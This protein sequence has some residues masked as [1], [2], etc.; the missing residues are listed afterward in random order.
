MRVL[1]RRLRLARAERELNALDALPRRRGRRAR[2]LRPRPPRRHPADPHPRLA[3]RVH[4]APAAG[5]APAESFDLVIPS[6][7]GYGFSERPDRCTTRDIASLWHT[8]MR[9][10]ATSATARAAATGAPAVT[11][12]MAL[13][14]RRAARHPPLQPR[15]RAAADGAADRGERAFLA[16]TAP[17]GRDE[18]GYSFI[19]GTA[20]DAGLR[21]HRLARG[22]AAG[23]SRSGARGPTPAATRGRFDRDFLLAL[24]T[25]Y[26][27]TGTISTS[28]RDYI[29]NRDAGTAA[30][31]TVRHRAAPGSPTSTTTSS[32]R[33]C[34][35]ASGPS[36][37][38]RRALHGHAPRRPL[39]R[40]RGNRTCSPPS[41]APSSSQ[42][43]TLRRCSSSRYCSVVRG[44]TSPLPQSRIT[45]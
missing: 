3:E 33:A 17:L 31:S 37:S 23:S 9:A 36:A 8:L 29:D 19:Q 38:T 13:D 44:S 12:Y 6:L 16:A 43:E 26:W 7:P 5:R 39:R 34:C 35:R 18:R 21:P 4:R 10:S 42:A 24:V 40:R 20:P 1:G 14:A 45:P 30:L 2:A 41:Y 27:V 22:L 15:Q 11:T 32:T 25:L 28:L